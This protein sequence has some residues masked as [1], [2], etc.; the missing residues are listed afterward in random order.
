M[1]IRSDRPRGSAAVTALR[2][3]CRLLRLVAAAAAGTAVAITVLK[4]MAGDPKELP[5]TFVL[6]VLVIVA[7]VTFLAATLLMLT[8]D[9]LAERAERKATQQCQLTSE[10]REAERLRETPFLARQQNRQQRP[11]LDS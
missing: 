6:M 9:R 7:M 2:I 4:A 10:E 11:P 5:S 8:A 1:S 3:L